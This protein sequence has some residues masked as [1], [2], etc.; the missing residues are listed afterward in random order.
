M[1][2]SGSSASSKR[3]QALAE[4]LG[5]KDIEEG[6]AKTLINLVER[7]LEPKVQPFANAWW[8]DFTAEYAAGAH[9]AKGAFGPFETQDQ[10]ELVCAMI[11]LHQ[12]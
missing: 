12:I 8:V 5:L 7:R 6:F 4:L 3:V 11:K 2:P 10:A 9:T 1:P